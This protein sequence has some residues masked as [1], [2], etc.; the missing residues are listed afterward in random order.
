M[1]IMEVNRQTGQRRPRNQ[2][3]FFAVAGLAE[4][5]I[6]IKEAME[7]ITINIRITNIQQSKVVCKLGPQPER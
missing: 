3:P 7:V 4:S 2:N 6:N 5:F 1:E